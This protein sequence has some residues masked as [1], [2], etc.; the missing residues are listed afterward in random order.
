M[1]DKLDAE[2]L[3]W[4]R[5][6]GYLWGASPANWSESQRALRA[7]SPWSHSQLSIWGNVLAVERVRSEEEL[8]LGTREGQ[9]DKQ[10]RWRE[11]AERRRHRVD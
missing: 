6:N 10:R 3:R 5:A 11:R 2:T 4:I 9:L 1:R 7:W 8:R